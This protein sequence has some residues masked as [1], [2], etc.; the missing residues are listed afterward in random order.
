M[1]L[2][3]GQI[4]E[5]VKKFQ[6]LSI[7]GRKATIS[8]GGR[9]SKV[10]HI[11]KHRENIQRCANEL[12]IRWSKDGTIQS[13]KHASRCGGADEKKEE[14]ARSVSQQQQQEHQRS[15]PV[16]Q[17]PH[18][19][20]TT[21]S[22]E[23][24]PVLIQPDP[25]SPPPFVRHT[26][27]PP[28]LRPLSPNKGQSGALQRTPDILSPRRGARS[29]LTPAHCPLT[30]SPPSSP[31]TDSC[32]SS[33]GEMNYLGSPRDP[34]SSSSSKKGPP[35]QPSDYDPPV[36]EN[37]GASAAS[38]WA[39]PPTRC[40][41]AEA[42]HLLRHDDDDIHKVLKKKVAGSSTRSKKR[43]RGIRPQ[44]GILATVGH[45][46]R[47]FSALASI[48]EVVSEEKWEEEEE[49]QFMARAMRESKQQP[50]AVEDLL[51][52]WREEHNAL[53]HEVANL[54]ECESLGA[55]EISV[56][57]SFSDP[58]AVLRRIKQRLGCTSPPTNAAA[59]ALY[60]STLARPIAP[61]S[62]LFFDPPH[63][64]KDVPLNSLGISLHYSPTHE[65][66]STSASDLNDIL[67]RWRSGTHRGIN[68]RPDIAHVNDTT[69]T[70]TRSSTS[71]TRSTYPVLRLEDAPAR[72]S[73]IPGEE[74]HFTPVTGNDVSY[75]EEN[76]N[77]RKKMMMMMSGE[78]HGK[79]NDVVE[80]NQHVVHR[81]M[82]RDESESFPHNNS[83][84]A[85][86]GS[87]GK[88]AG[89][90]SPRIV[91]DYSHG[92]ARGD[93]EIGGTGVLV[94]R[95]VGKQAMQQEILITADTF[96]NNLCVQDSGSGPSGSA[97]YEKGESGLLPSNPLSPTTPLVE[98]RHPRALLP[99]PS[100]NLEEGSRR[101]ISHEEKKQKDKNVVASG[102]GIP[103][104]ARTRDAAGSGGL[105]T[106]TRLKPDEE[107]VHINTPPPTFGFGT[108][109][110]DLHTNSEARAGGNDDDD[111]III[112]ASP[113]AR[114]H[115]DS[116]TTHH[117]LTSFMENVSSDC[118]LVELMVR[119]PEGVNMGPRSMR[120][121][122]V[123]DIRDSIL[124]LSV[125]SVTPR[126]TNGDLMEQTEYQMEQAGLFDSVSDIGQRSLIN[127]TQGGSRGN[128]HTR[129]K[130]RVGN[131]PPPKTDDDS[132]NRPCES[133]MMREGKRDKG[134]FEDELLVAHQKNN[135]P[136]EKRVTH[137]QEE[138][139]KNQISERPM[140][141]KIFASRA[142]EGD[143]DERKH[144]S[145]Q[146]HGG[147]GERWTN[148]EREESEGNR[149]RET[150]GAHGGMST[151]MPQKQIGGGGSQARK[152]TPL[153]CAPN[154]GDTGTHE[155]TQ[156]TSSSYPWEQTSRLPAV[157]TTHSFV[158]GLSSPP[159][160]PHDDMAHMPE[161]AYIARAHNSH[162]VINTYG[163]HQS[164]KL[165]C[166]IKEDKMNESGACLLSRSPMIW[167][168]EDVDAAVQT[169]LGLC[170]GLPL[171]APWERDRDRTYAECCEPS[172]WDRRIAGGEDENELKKRSGDDR[173]ERRYPWYD[174]ERI[175]RQLPPLDA[176]SLS[177]MHSRCT[178]AP[179]R[180]GQKKEEADAVL[181]TYQL[182]REQQQVLA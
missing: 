40:D 3:P 112:D 146:R 74:L 150:K 93:D 168:G 97:G 113:Y 36:F 28:S 135:L 46:P 21:M 155:E 147:N 78:L 110:N 160:L 83:H 98:D 124:T 4:A 32:H 9:S 29:L 153:D 179:T 14:D 68:E 58:D 75:R 34:S 108:N 176:I 19:Y 116:S 16:Y 77:S 5:R 159:P 47:A 141:G 125:D 139:I 173:D 85:A 60:A 92:H 43:E 165:K 144:E 182:F 67:R 142:A 170:N 62:T 13:V 102:G 103:G 87:E 99:V 166:M 95:P 140:N 151:Q 119:L 56:Q 71:T 89:M 128:H 18:R 70:N 53:Q 175:L 169:S 91:V 65:P 107:K 109:I 154:N 42:R 44:N 158:E 149:T 174:L 73:V 86:H 50:E 80:K 122:E 164:N 131:A 177:S 171:A 23:E 96:N 64:P 55:C 100:L 26:H 72:L 156:K 31:H 117:S 181:K 111:A 12:G 41:T 138:P 114:V 123:R 1:V 120:Y 145:P 25:M 84:N 20:R 57:D 10:D 2:G 7:Q 162:S 37:A 130:L 136:R 126:V 11:R 137:V 105:P 129:D 127:T 152:C 106:T 59:H 88:T 178:R 35:F 76:I 143:D 61:S 148:W 134:G 49:Q 38:A 24:R 118:S 63:R 27:S 8:P 79:E 82:E 161:G 115:N 94:E 54:P 33:S 69:T 90:F 132:L 163:A 30:M 81:Q 121:D 180:F 104:Q 45:N 51:A 48:E 66:L 6:D 133:V 39:G 101:D 157:E 17:V 15:P 22:R 167:E 172:A 52:K